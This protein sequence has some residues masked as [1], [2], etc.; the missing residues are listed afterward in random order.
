MYG[1]I[2]LTECINPSSSFFHSKYIGQHKTNNLDDGYLGSGVVISR[3]LEKY[4]P[5]AFIRKVLRVCNS[6]EELDYYEKYYIELYDALH[7][8][9][10]MNLHEG[11]TGGFSS[12]N[13]THR[14]RP[15]PMKGKHQTEYQRSK[16]S[17]MMKGNKIALNSK[18]RLGQKN[19]EETRLLLS[20]A[21]KGRI[22]HNKGIPMSEEQK[23]KLSNSLKKAY[24]E[25]PELSANISETI[26]KRNFNCIW[27]TNGVEDKF[28]DKDT[29]KMYEGYTLGRSKISNKSK[30]GYRFINNGIENRQIGPDEEVPEGWLLGMRRRPK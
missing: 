30:T 13:E 8:E 4:G 7:S 23:F 17:A 16:Q 25:R 5:E 2:Y 21:L 6:K 28:V 19:S 1:I 24:S 11:G 9:E 26:S 14:G 22:A 27:I 10:Y 12:Y 29:L 20:K 15:S 3:L 18:G